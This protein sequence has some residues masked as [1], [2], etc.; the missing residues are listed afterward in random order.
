M[1]NRQFLIGQQVYT[2]SNRKNNFALSNQDVMAGLQNSSAAM[3]VANNSLEETIAL[4][5]SG[6]EIVQDA[7]QVGNGLRTGFCA[8]AQKCA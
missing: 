8:Y 1:T 6:T 7:S 5:A 3:S 4:I 2:E